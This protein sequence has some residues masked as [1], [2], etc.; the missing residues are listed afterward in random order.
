MTR[1]D[2]LSRR[3][4]IAAAGGVAA[5]AATLRVGD[6]RRSD[7]EPPIDS[8]M[9]IGGWIVENEDIDAWI[10]DHGDIRPTPDIRAS[11]RTDPL[12]DMAG[13]SLPLG[14]CLFCHNRF[15]TMANS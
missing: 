7:E 14:F 8:V 13:V 3:A 2:L 11:F 5:L 6:G 9:A 15:L 4:A 12:V 10:A 1:K